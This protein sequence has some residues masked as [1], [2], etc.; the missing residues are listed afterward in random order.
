MDENE[1][2]KLGTE[3]CSSGGLGTFRTRLGTETFFRPDR[4]AAGLSAYSLSPS[5][6]AGTQTPFDGGRDLSGRAEPFQ[7]AE[8]QRQTGGRDCAGQSHARD[9]AAFGADV[10]ASDREQSHA[11]GQYDW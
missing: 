9:C 11:P 2:G 4:R 7:L 3:Q 8:L 6:V 1:I 10:H 5:M